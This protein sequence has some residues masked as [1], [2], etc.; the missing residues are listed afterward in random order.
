MKGLVFTEFM[1]LVEEKFGE[2]MLDDLIDATNPASGGAYTAV[3]TYDHQELVAMVVE[4]SERTGADVPTLIKTFGHHLAQ[5]FSTKFG[6]FF[7]EVDNTIDFLKRI[8]DHIHVEV[9][10]L[11]PDAE[12]PEFSFDDRDPGRFCLDYASTRGLQDLAHGL[13][14]AVSE[15]YGESFKIERQDS[16][17]GNLHRSRFILHHS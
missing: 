12:L 2:D 10:K 13:I 9:A 5:V 3:G 16:V 1:N 17:D 11:Y 8:D 7:E 6:S 4:L 14:E 15:H